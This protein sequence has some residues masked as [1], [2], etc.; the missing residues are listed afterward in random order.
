MPS[1]AHRFWP[2]LLAFSLGLLAAALTGWD[3]TGLVWSLWLSS[4]TI[5][6]LTIVL[7]I[8]RMMRSGA[9]ALAKEIPAE[10]ARAAAPALAIFGGLFL[11]AFFTIHFGGFHW[12]H[13]IFLNVFFPIHGGEAMQGAPMPTAADYWQIAQTGWWFI[14]L[15]LIAERRKLFPH[16]DS[17][18]LEHSLGAPYKNVVR[19]HLLIFFFA[20]A[21]FSGAPAFLIY[22]VV[23]AVYFFPWGFWKKA[24]AKSPEENLATQ[25]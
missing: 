10:K 8:V 19:L 23:Y 16:A 7:T 25:P 18:Q 2:E 22:I 15:A 11:L 24:Q 14:P 9:S 5:G 21:S 3:T 4:L 13:S 17:G 6:Y 1:R 12:G 20:G